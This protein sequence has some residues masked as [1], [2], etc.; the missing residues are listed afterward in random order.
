M[1]KNTQNKISLKEHSIPIVQKTLSNSQKQPISSN[2][3]LQSIH[4]DVK[5]GSTSNSYFLNKNSFKDHGY[6]V[7][8]KMKRNSV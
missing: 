2:V 1:M 5:S 7:F 6:I 3:I 8:E 4:P